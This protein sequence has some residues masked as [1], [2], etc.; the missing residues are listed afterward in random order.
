LF[1]EEYR[2]G[3]MK[4]NIGITIIITV[5]A[6]IFI[7][8]FGF[9]FITSTLALSDAMGRVYIALVI[10]IA[11]GFIYALIRNMEERIREIKD[12]DKDDYDK[13]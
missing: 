8:Y 3:R 10:V 9:E 1:Y 12:E 6:T 4:K 2:G 5:A 7:T 13:Y 11:L